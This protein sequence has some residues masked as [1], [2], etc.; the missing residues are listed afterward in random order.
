MKLG[1]RV[2][3]VLALA[4][5]AGAGVSLLKLWFSCR[6]PESE[7]CVWGKAY[8]PLSLPFES[9]AIGVLF[10][11]VLAGVRILMRRGAARG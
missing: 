1:A 3:G 5:A 9:V 7:A 8:L 6:Q 11:M 4:L 10:L 2:F